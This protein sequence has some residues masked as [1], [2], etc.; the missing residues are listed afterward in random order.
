LPT[1]LYALIS[2]PG[3]INYGMAMA[4]TALLILLTFAL[5]AAVS[6]RPKWSVFRRARRS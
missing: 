5:V 3:G 1:V 4:V 6:A 2:R